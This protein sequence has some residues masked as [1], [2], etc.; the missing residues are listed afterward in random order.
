MTPAL[1][2]S[3]SRSRP[4]LRGCSVAGNPFWAVFLDVDGTVLKIAPTPD[5]VEVSESLKHVLD[6]LRPLL[7]GAL[8]LVSGRTIAD[9][10]YLF[11]PLHLPAAGLHGL[12]RRDA[13]GNLH[14]EA[15]PGA[16]GDIRAALEEFASDHAGVMVEDKTHAVAVHYRQA[17]KAKRKLRVE[18]E[19]LVAARDDLQ[20]LDGKMVFEIRPHGIDKGTAIKAFLAE[21][22]FVGRQPIFLGDD[23]TD[24]DGFA[25]VN[26]VG[27]HTIR[28]GG[29]GKTAA[30]FR[31]PDVA[32]VIEWL[33]WLA[34]ELETRGTGT[35]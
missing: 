28:V 8:A 5:V 12:E 9:L 33:E 31:L 30:R 21:P 14:R 15:K 23:V 17:P 6:K 27:G 11:A 22:P 7:G 35:A 18:V 3:R 25:F 24:E 34:E 26:E 32:A 2:K 29:R 20:V 16:L 10:D 4:P 19:R 1:P 13:R